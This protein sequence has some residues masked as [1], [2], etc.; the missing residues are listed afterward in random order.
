MGL[1]P[2][3]H[4]TLNRIRTRNFTSFSADEMTSL[5]IPR[6]VLYPRFYCWL[7]SMHPF[8]VQYHTLRYSTCWHLHA[9]ARWIWN[10]VL[11]AYYPIHLNIECR[12][13][14]HC[15]TQCTVFVRDVDEL[16]SIT[17]TVLRQ[18]SNP[19]FSHHRMTGNH[20]WPHRA[21]NCNDITKTC[22]AKDLFSVIWLFS[23]QSILFHG[24]QIL[25]AYPFPGKYTLTFIIEICVCDTSSCNYLTSWSFSF[26][27]FWLCSLLSKTIIWLVRILGISVIT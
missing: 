1:T 24:P 9:D 8:S 23:I 18:S 5:L 10:W 15:I 16:S 6:Y 21:L 7:Q 22:I 25:V 4:S 11:I 14:C 27:L 13:L 20:K 26:V 2:S 12:G 19:H 3:T 17:P